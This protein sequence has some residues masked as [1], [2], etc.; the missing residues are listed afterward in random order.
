[1]IVAVMTTALAGTVKAE[2]VTYSLTPNQASTGS[3]ATSYITTTTEFSYNGISWKMNQW[4]PNTLQIK[5]N[6]SSYNLQ[7]NFRNT[8]AFPG[9]ITQV[10]MSFSTLT[11]IEPA[12]L[13]FKGG[14]SE[15]TQTGSGTAGTWDATNKTL[16]WTPASS[17]EFTYFA[18]YQNG[19]AASG[20]NYLA[21]TDAIVVTYEE[22]GSTLAD[23]DLALTNAPIVLNFDLYNNAEPQ[24]ISYTTSST[25]VVTVSESEYVNCVVN[26]T[27]KAITVT[28]K[29]VTSGAQTITVSQASDD[30]YKAGSAT[31]TVN[32]TDSTPFVG[33]IFIFNT[34]AGLQDL[35]INKPSSGDGTNL[36]VNT[37]YT[38]DNVT[39]NVTHGGT[40]T[41]VWNSN[42]ST[43]L[44]VYKN[45][46]SLTF[47][48]PIGYK[49]NKITFTGSSVNFSNVTNN[50]WQGTPASSVTLSATNTSNITTITVEYEVSNDPVLSADDINIACNAVEG[51]ITYT[52]TNPV[53]GGVL[54]AESSATW[55]TIG[56]IGEMV[57]F[58]CTVNEA[59]TV[60]TATVTLTYTYGTETLT[61]EVLVTQ[62]AAPL[63]Y[64]TI[65][66]LF[67]AATNTATDV[68]INF[69]G[70]VI[71][72]VKGSN[73]Y[74][75]DN[76]G[77]GLIIYASSHG[78]QVNDVLTGTV[79]CKL[80]TY[81][82]S[83]ELT[84]LTSSTTGLSVANTGSVTEQNIAINELGGVNTGALVVY[85]GLTYNGTVLVD[86]SNN[87]ITPYSTLYSYTFEKG[88][89]YNVK[90]IYLQYNTTKELLPR[91][92]NDIEEV[93]VPV[94]TYT[95]TIANSENVTI[96]A[97]YGEGEDAPV[98]RGNDCP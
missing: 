69:G 75:T 12:K 51:V 91:S 61:K 10:V 2:S 40:A 87:A 38:I 14:T 67:E 37:D 6:Q 98:L 54:T 42:G 97:T 32:V 82:G 95:L 27:T 89:Q 43:D 86:D 24:T 33:S 19:K 90:G 16:T 45:G 63:I 15:I 77:H 80:Q 29:A 73:A 62:A 78:F 72:A 57:P 46:G 59:N 94:E 66:A 1:M 18:F 52:L 4:N 83:A 81:N 17:D 92:A 65:P 68:T 26:K 74:L 30:A 25:G 21:S 36:N 22:S 58:T 93:E 39:M 71:S 85:E 47:T 49:I 3:T 5:T 28:P 11:V 79:S 56:T 76:Q 13:L 8:S 9:K 53:D 20:N 34:D 60:R 48:V 7:F 84:N 50:V 44:R 88:K 96:T 64:T 70:W 41:R 35:G 55:L 23:C 31:F